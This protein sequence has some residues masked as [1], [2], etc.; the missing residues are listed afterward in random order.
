MISTYGGVLL[1]FLARV[2]CDKGEVGGRKRGALGRVLL[3]SK[4]NSQNSV[5]TF[6]GSNRIYDVIKG[7]TSPGLGI[8]P[9]HSKTTSAEKKG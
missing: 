2:E 4:D 9:K 3:S 5:A 6:P 7:W 1:R 8:R